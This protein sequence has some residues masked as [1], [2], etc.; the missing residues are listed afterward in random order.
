ML[1]LNKCGMRIYTLKTAGGASDAH[2]HSCCVFSL[3]SNNVSGRDAHCCCKS[4]QLNVFSTCLEAEEIT[5]E[6][7]SNRI[8]MKSESRWPVSLC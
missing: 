7:G 3:T 6:D 5:A 8:I 2:I 1:L 4:P